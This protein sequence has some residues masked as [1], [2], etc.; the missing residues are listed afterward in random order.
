MELKNVNL[1][2]LTV[3]TIL[4]IADEL[5]CPHQYPKM[6]FNISGKRNDE[7]VMKENNL[8]FDEYYNNVINQLANNHYIYYNY[9]G[10]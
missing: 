7:E 1:S 5:G 6:D 2:K 3:G 9:G 4:S 8:K 10:E